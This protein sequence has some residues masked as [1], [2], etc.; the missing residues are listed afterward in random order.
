MRGNDVASP[1]V[2]R[3]IL[4][5]AVVQRGRSGLKNGVHTHIRRHL[6]FFWHCFSS[7]LGKVAVA[8][9]IAW[10]VPKCFA[11]CVD[12]GGVSRTSNGARFVVHG[13]SFFAVR[14]AVVV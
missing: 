9:E 8:V 5:A 7:T 3:G 4:A 11:A 13:L 1:R 6:R 12:P 2:S 10:Q 14:A